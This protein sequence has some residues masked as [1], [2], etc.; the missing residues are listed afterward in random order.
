M[1]DYEYDQEIKPNFLLSLVEYEGETGS[2]GGDDA[3]GNVTI[4]GDTL[5]IDVEQDD[6]WIDGVS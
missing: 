5:L 3:G 6:V 1:A 2:G 4:L